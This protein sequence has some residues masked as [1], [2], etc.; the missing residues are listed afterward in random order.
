M[1][2]AQPIKG[3]NS[4]VKFTPQG[5]SEVLIKN[6]DWEIM[7]KNLIGEAPN[8]SDGMLRAKGMDDYEGSVKGYFD[9]TQ[10]I[11]TNITQGT[12][13][14]LKLYRDLTHFWT[15]TVIIASFKESTGVDAFDMWEF[16]YSKQSGQLIPPTFP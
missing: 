3:V 13:G 5:S 11:D 14:T 8:T 6:S 15:A 4:L 1:A 7:P 12:I 9:I 2:N 10:P 16:S